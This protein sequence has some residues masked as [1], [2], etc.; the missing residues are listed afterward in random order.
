MEGMRERWMERRE[1]DGLRGG[2]EGG[3]KENL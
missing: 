3:I 2:R 1:G